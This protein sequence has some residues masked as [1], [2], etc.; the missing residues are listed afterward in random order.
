MADLVG[1]HGF[2][3]IGGEALQQ[4]LAHGHQCIVAVPAGGEGVG[5]VGGEDADFRHLD[6]GFAGQLLDGLQ[7]PLL[8]AGAGLGDDLGTGAHLRHPLGDEQRNQ[9]AGEAEH[10]TE[11]QQAAVVLAGETVYAQQFQGDAG[12]HQDCKVRGQEQQN[13]H[14]DWNGLLTAESG[15][16]CGVYKGRP[17]RI[18]PGTISNYVAHG[19]RTAIED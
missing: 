8:V 1:Q 12:N 18:Q 15:F 11:N 4:A 14:H 6:A 10:G 5:L 3:F 16:V 7:Q 19:V 2:H 9:G 13:A 17:W